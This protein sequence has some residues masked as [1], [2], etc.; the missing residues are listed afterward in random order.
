MGNGENAGI[1]ADRL[2]RPPSASVSLSQVKDCLR[3]YIK[4]R[5]QGAALWKHVK[6]EGRPLEP[7]QHALKMAME[8]M[9]AQE[10]QGVCLACGF[11]IWC[12]AF[13][14]QHEG[15][16][17]GSYVGRYMGHMGLGFEFCVFGVSGLLLL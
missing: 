1:S 16:G 17:C 3:S 10:A 5:K 8:K 6:E 15:A 12:L 7:S 2:M 11:C 9:E 4:Y 14:Q 13:F